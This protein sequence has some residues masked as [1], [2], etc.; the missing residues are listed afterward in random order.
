MFKVMILENINWKATAK[1]NQMM[2]NQYQDEK[3]QPIYSVIDKGRVMKMP[4]NGLTLLDYAINATLVISNIA[5][6]KN[7]KAG[8]FSFSNKIEN[9]VAAERRNSQMN[10]ILENALQSGNQFCG[11]RL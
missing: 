7:D 2:V 6:K 9:R 10:L 8:M 5:I 4:F 1:R 11:K 3:S